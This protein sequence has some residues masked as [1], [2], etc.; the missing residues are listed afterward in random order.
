[1]KNVININRFGAENKLNAA[2][3]NIN[4]KMTCMKTKTQTYTQKNVTRLHALQHCTY[5]CTKQQKAFNTVCFYQ[6]TQTN[7]K[8]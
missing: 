3:S 1:M 6:Y 4:A 7:M 8:K 2:L 5:V